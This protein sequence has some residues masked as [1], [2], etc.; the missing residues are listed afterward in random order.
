MQRHKNCSEI[1]DKVV[2]NLQNIKMIVIS[3]NAEKM[4][5]FAVIPSRMVVSGN[6]GHG[7][8]LHFR[9]VCLRQKNVERDDGRKACKPL[10]SVFNG[11]GTIIWAEVQTPLA[12]QSQ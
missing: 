4:K 6:R 2:L 1:A 3:H 5:A 7:K 10:T 9:G 12:N 11:P 8:E